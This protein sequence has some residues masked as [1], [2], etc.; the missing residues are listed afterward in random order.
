V[1]S[2]F[3]AGQWATVASLSAVAVSFTHVVKALEPAIN[4]VASAFILGQVFHPAVY[5]ALV[6]IFLGVALASASEVS[7]TFYGFWTALLS[8]FALVARNVLAT[9]WGTIGDMGEDKVERKTNQLAV[10]TIVA[11]IVAFPFALLLPNGL[12]DFYEAWELA[13]SQGE[14]PWRLAY[15]LSA[16][17]FHFFMYQL[18]SF[19]VLSQAPPITHSVLNTLK[20]LVVIV[21]AIVAFDTPVTAQSAAGTAVAIAGVLLYSV[22]KSQCSKKG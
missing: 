5:A 6:P 3:A 10:V 2:F 16:S 1:G 8:N 13:V 18:S 15:L 9:K 17:C 20:R 22:T 4:A 14:S 12:M 7:F 19:W 11:S 21:F